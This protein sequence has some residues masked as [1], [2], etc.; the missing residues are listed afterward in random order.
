VLNRRGEEERGR[1][2]GLVGKLACLGWL[3]EMGQ[4]A[5]GPVKKKG[6]KI[7]ISKLISRFRKIDYRVSGGWNNWKKFPKIVENL[8]RQECEFESILEGKNLEREFLD[9]KE[10]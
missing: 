10:F 1:G 5:N 2:A 8:G 3:G 4:V 6:I 9:F 7:W